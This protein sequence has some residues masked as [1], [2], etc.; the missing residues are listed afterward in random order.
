MHYD[1]VDLKEFYDSYKSEKIET[2]IEKIRS[3]TI[4]FNKKYKNTLKNLSNKKIIQ[5]CHT[6]NNIIYNILC[7]FT[8]Y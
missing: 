5:T 6:W 8:F 7:L 3:S 2:D 4:N 1:A